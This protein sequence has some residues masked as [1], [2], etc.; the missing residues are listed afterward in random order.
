MKAWWL[1]L[2][3]LLGIVHLAPV[4]PVYE[5]TTQNEAYAVD[6]GQYSNEQRLRVITIFQPPECSMSRQATKGDTV[7]VSYLLKLP[8]GEFYHNLAYHT[9]RLGRAQ[10]IRGWDIGISGM[11]VGEHRRLVI[12]PAYA[13]G[14][15]GFV[16]TDSDEAGR[17]FNVPPQA[18]VIFD[19]SLVGITAH[20]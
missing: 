11:C 8:T 19:V 18:V 16:A 13:Y 3:C 4:E 12:P 1:W 15:E 2:V 5:E 14:T 10:V 6:L 7:S 9:F 20:E 17:T